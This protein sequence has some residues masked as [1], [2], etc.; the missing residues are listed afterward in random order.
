VFIVI[1]LILL[2]LTSYNQ[3][4]E[5]WFDNDNIKLLL[6]SLLSQNVCYEDI[7]NLFSEY[8]LMSH[9]FVFCIK[10]F[11]LKY[12]KNLQK[13]LIAYCISNS[14][15]RLTCFYS[16]IISN[17][18]TDSFCYAESAVLNLKNKIIKLNCKLRDIIAEKSSRNIFRLD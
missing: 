17:D 18:Q 16:K 8:K 7:F 11:E 12:L 4:S 2:I 15:F 9:K 10:H 3:S 5:I 6:Q 13:A 1:M 14:F